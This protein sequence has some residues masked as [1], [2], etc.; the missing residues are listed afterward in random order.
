M[1]SLFC[2]LPEGEENKYLDIS[3]GFELTVVKVGGE[4]TVSGVGKG[5]QQRERTDFFLNFN[6]N[7][8]QYKYSKKIFLLWN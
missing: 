1:D 4:R 7:Q 2:K 6:K 8:D 3:S 5:Q